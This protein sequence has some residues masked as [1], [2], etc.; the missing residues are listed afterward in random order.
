M[1]IVVIVLILLGVVLFAVST[2]TTHPTRN[3]VAAGLFC[4]SLAVLLEHLTG[5]IT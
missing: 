2:F 3:L 4:W 5:H 1:G